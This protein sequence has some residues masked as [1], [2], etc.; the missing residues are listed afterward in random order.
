M[1]FQPLSKCKELTELYLHSNHPIENEFKEIDIGPLFSCDEL[2]DIGIGD[3][4]NLYAKSSLQDSKDI[5]LAIEELIE[6]DRI[7][8]S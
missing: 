3:E 8:W 5:P 7:T 6:D 4:T 2:E 1:D